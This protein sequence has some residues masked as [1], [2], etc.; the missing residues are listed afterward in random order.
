MSEDNVYRE[1]KL[2]DAVPQ[3]DDSAANP[4]GGPPEATHETEAEQHRAAEASQQAQDAQGGVKDRL[5]DIGKAHH[6]GGRA[7]GRVSDR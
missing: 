1:H 2:A 5:V 4:A 3:P 6:M 7:Q